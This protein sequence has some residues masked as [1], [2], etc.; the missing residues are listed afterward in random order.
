MTD[1][2]DRLNKIE[3]SIQ[4]NTISSISNNDLIF[5]LYNNSKNEEL[6]QTTNNNTNITNFL[7]KIKNSYCY[8]NIF[9]NTN[10]YSSIVISIIALLVP[11]YYFF[12]RFYNIGIFA[13]VIGVM[14]FFGLGGVISNLYSNFFKYFYLIYF[15]LTVIIYIV[16]F[17]VLNQLH[18]V[19]LFFI[20][21]VIA[22]LLIN[23]I[24][25]I[26]LA[27]PTDANQ[28]NKYAAT[29]NTNNVNNKNNSKY[30]PYNKN[31][32]A[33]CI[34]INK[35]Y[36]LGLPSGNM[37]Y[38][39]LTVFSITPQTQ[40]SQIINFIV[41]LLG[42]LFAIGLLFMLGNL[43]SLFKE[44]YTLLPVIGINE[45]SDKY[46]TC[47]A[48]Y[49]LPA[50]LNVDFMINDIIEKYKDTYKSSILDKISKAL[51]RIS[52]E[53]IE[54]YQ[55]TFYQLGAEEMALSDTE[56]N[57]ISNNK[58]M[59][60]EEKI[61]AF[62]ELNEIKN[63]LFIKKQDFTSFND[64][65]LAREVLY[66]E[67][68]N[69]SNSSE[70][71]NQEDNTNIKNI[72][73]EFYN[74]FIQHL[75]KKND[76]EINGYNYNLITF[77][78][79]PMSVRNTANNIFKFIIRLI[80]TWFLIGKIIGSSLFIA[81]MIINSNPNIGNIKNIISNKGFL[82]KF[83]SMGLDLSYFEDINI[84]KSSNSDSNSDS[85]INNKNNENLGFKW[86]YLI[87]YGIG[88]LFLMPTLGYC[89]SA[90]FGLVLS[91][92]YNNFIVMT[93]IG[94]GIL[95]NILRVKDNQP[96][97][98]FNIGY[99]ILMIIIFIIIQIIMNYVKK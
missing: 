73:E 75:N 97:L 71:E 43:T 24:G 31:I 8:E 61:E 11:F 96:L 25:K 90:I 28:Y 22:F 98:S 94:I 41:V 34:E 1:I 58:N 79:L 88:L 2:K 92:L 44:E 14:G 36:N 52:N 55:P 91:P 49:I 17:L 39:Y 4:N 48:N 40:N 62:K 54:R 38:S 93:V 60:N 69:S 77:N 42:P 68:S 76:E 67:L 46:F 95:I 30:I 20:S 86:S 56:W 9:V 63:K 70:I 99:I 85:E 37:L 89:N 87:Y 3:F 66:K 32:E 15:V 65:G 83:I 72:V 47:Q 59:S 74:S 16:F 64:S 45:S 19:S 53:L 78:I 35:R 18:H 27:V 80:S 81:H 12:P 5:Y 50:E 7:N 57:A 6:N 82:W 84:S 26:I 13:T 21:A 10:N 33:V 23:Y 51:R 29:I